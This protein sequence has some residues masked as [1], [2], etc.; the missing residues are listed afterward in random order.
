M[1]TSSLEGLPRYPTQVARSLSFCLCVCLSVR[2]PACPP[3]CLPVS[4]SLSPYASLRHYF[5]TFLQVGFMVQTFSDKL[6]GLEP[7][8]FQQVVSSLVFGSQ[9]VSA[10]RGRA[11]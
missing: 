9:T 11:V 5:S 3:V 7:E 2:L 4:P 10:A 1:H 8:L 6:A